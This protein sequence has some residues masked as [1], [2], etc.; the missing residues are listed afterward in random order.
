MSSNSKRNPIKDLTNKKVGR[1][2]II[3]DTGKR[4]S[5]R[6]VIWKCLCDC[7]NIVNVASCN[8]SSESTISCGCS[9]RKAP[10]ESTIHRIWLQYKGSAKKRNIELLLDKEQFISFIFN[11]CYYCGEKPY[12]LIKSNNKYN[13]QW[14][15]LCSVYYNGIDRVD[16]N[17]GYSINNCVTC[18]QKCNAAKSNMKVEQFFKMIKN[19]YERHIKNG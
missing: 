5:S 18:C 13:K 6:G 16:N 3:Q 14:A 19:I 1:L 15:D 9:R 11:D 12:T 4:S 17:L 10:K 8:L 2:L 7:G